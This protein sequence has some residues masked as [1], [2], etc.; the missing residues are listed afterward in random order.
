LFKQIPGTNFA[1][2]EIT[3][4][5]APDADYAG[6]KKR[7]LGVAEA[8]LA[9]YHDEMERQHQA[10]ESTFATDSNG[11]HPS[12]HLRLTPLGLEVTLRFPVDLQHASEIDERLNRELLQELDR[13]P[14]LKREGAP[15]VKTTV[16]S[17]V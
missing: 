8:V 5:L 15:E 3:L 9:D 13:E 1:W 11:F 7:L 10:L 17:R 2:H 4:T 12:A 14:K 16:A 6:V